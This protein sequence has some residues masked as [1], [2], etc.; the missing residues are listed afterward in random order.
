ML[1][2]K[3]CFAN[4]NVLMVTGTVYTT[5][6]KTYQFFMTVKKTCLRKEV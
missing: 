1:C 5:L 2:F 6:E 3:L 4:G